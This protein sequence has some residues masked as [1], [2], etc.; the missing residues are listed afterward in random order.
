MI[1]HFGAVARDSDPLPK[2]IVY[3]MGIQKVIS[4][5]LFGQK[6]TKHYWNMNFLVGVTS[7]EAKLIAI[8]FATFQ[9]KLKSADTH[10]LSHLYL[11]ILQDLLT[12]SALNFQK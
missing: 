2:N 10:H 5:S 1:K 11:E 8:T 12:R 7:D 9:T 3:L 4:S 6:L